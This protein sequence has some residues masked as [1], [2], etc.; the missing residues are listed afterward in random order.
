M[1]GETKFK[2]MIKLFV[3]DMA[4]TTVDCT[5]AVHDCLIGAFQKH[6]YTIDRDIASRSI[7]VP[8]P[9]GIRWILREEFDITEDRVADTILS[10]FLVFM[11]MYYRTDPS[12]QPMPGTETLFSFLKKEGI[13]IA[14]DTG[15]ARE[16]ADV[17]IKRL[18][19][20]ERIDLSVASDE[21]ENGRPYP[22]MI[23]KAMRRFDIEEG[24]QVVKVGDT[25]ADMKQGKNA[26]CLLTIGVS[27]GAFTSDELKD[28]G[29]DHIVDQP[30]EIIQI[31]EK[32][33]TEV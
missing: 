32:Y 28:A 4:G 9:V 21:V 3:F 30:D 27:S 14:L 1:A 16:T 5:F 11:N 13:R 19:W 17:I 10:D 31:L 2:T 24:N 22:D 12:V 6:G 29:A 8:K 26:G 20:E 15:F 18:Q 23:V 25:P 7:A 33:A